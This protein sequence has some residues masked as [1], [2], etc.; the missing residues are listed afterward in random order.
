ME[1]MV[2]LMGKEFHDEPTTSLTLAQ[3]HA[4]AGETLH[5][6]HTRCT[7]S[8]GFLDLTLSNLFTPTDN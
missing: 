5:L 7:K 6:V 1:G 3:S 2:R 8:D 4:C